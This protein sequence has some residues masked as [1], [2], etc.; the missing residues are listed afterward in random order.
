ME[1][2]I[3]YIYCAYIYIF[4]FL[5]VVADC[6]WV[7]RYETCYKRKL[8]VGQSSV[9][10][11]KTRGIFTIIVVYKK[12]STGCYKLHRINSYWDGSSK[13]VKK[14]DKIMLFKIN[15]KLNTRVIWQKL[16]LNNTSTWF[17]S[18]NLHQ[19]NHSSEGDQ[20]IEIAINTI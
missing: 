16:L 19:K 6:L 4:F 13:G 9:L 11:R 3:Y 18:I 15:T 17:R 12:R 1:I 8:K 7:M 2:F 20:K 10:V 14:P 5:L